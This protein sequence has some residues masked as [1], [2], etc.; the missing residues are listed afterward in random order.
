M[1]PSTELKVTAETLVFPQNNLARWYKATTSTRHSPES[2]LNTLVDCSAAA[3]EHIHLLTQSPL[4]NESRKNI[5]EYLESLQ[6]HYQQLGYSQDIS[7][8]AHYAVCATLDDM[9]R[10]IGSDG[11][12]LQNFH[13]SRLEQEKFYS[14]LEH[15]SPKAEKYIDLLEL[16]YL[17][18]RFGYKGQYRNTPFGLQQWSLLTDNTYHLITH[19]RGQRSHVLS[20]GLSVATLPRALPLSSEIRPLTT[21]KKQHRFYLSVLVA[22]IFFAILTGFVFRETYNTTREALSNAPSIHSTTT[23]KEA[24]T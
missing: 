19:I 12:F 6:K 16:M 23:M 9:L 22:F 13:N 15:I 14:I 7:L 10:C 4:S 5:E 3:F 1:N 17:C 2:G 11:Q 8:A 21:N 18:L 24:A 20:P